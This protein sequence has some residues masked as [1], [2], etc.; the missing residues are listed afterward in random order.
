MNDTIRVAVV[1]GILLIAFVII[2]TPVSAAAWSTQSYRFTTSINP[3]STPAFVYSQTASPNFQY[4]NLNNYLSSG[5]LVVNK[6][7]LAIPSLAV[8]N[9]NWDSLFYQAPAFKYSCG[10]N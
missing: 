5:P 10:C 6:N 4:A 3:V 8:S 9:N 1:I 2:T 7:A